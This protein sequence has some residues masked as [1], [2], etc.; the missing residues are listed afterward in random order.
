MYDDLWNTE[1]E[2]DEIRMLDRQCELARLRGRLNYLR[3]ICHPHRRHGDRR[4]LQV[5]KAA[6]I[7]AL[8]AVIVIAALLL[9]LSR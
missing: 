7:V 9:P 1:H 2:R 6:A 4:R 3:S 5:I 8:A